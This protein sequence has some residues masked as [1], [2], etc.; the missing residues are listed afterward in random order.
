MIQLKELLNVYKE[1]CTST[2]QYR[3]RVTPLME[4]LS[5]LATAEE[6]LNNALSVSM[7]LPDRY[8]IRELREKIDNALV[9]LEDYKNDNID[10]VLGK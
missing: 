4:T 3:T 8:G 9:W 10:G 1:G 6:M 7:S 5:Y 2:E